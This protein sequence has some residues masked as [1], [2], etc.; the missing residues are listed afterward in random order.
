MK[1]PHWI[2]IFG[3]F[4]GCFAATPANQP[5]AKKTNAPKATPKSAPKAAPKTATKAA[6]NT[7]AAPKTAARKPAA[8]PGVKT[9]ARGKGPARPVA[10]T[11]RSRQSVPTPERYKEIQE[12]LA[13]KGYLKSEPNGVW[14]A[15]SQDAMKQFQNDH[16][17]T[18]TGKLSAASLIGLG[19]GPKN[20]SDPAVLPPPTSPTSTN[21]PAETPRP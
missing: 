5:A 18:P 19:L 21:P 1:F 7:K 6:G 8:K 9:A 12:A 11:W 17:L 14:D 4:T 16:Q 3:L 15:Q 13:S 2:L 10:S 20:S